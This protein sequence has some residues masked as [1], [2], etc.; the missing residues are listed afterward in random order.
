MSDSL[1]KLHEEEALRVDSFRSAPFNHSRFNH[2]TSPRC[3]ISGYTTDA[4]SGVFV[5]A[6]FSCRRKLVCSTTI[7]RK[8]LHE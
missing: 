7:H 8:S 1:H 2:L 6:R 3:F 4:G 5:K